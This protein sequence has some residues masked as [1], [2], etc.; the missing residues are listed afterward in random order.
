ML[1]NFVHYLSDLR[2][3]IP[4]RQCLGCYLTVDIMCLYLIF[5]DILKY[6]LTGCPMAMICSETMKYICVIAMFIIYNGSDRWSI[7][8][9]LSEILPVK[10]KGIGIYCYMLRISIYLYFFSSFILYEYRQHYLSTAITCTIIVNVLLLLFLFAQY[11][12]LKEGDE[13]LER[14]AARRFEK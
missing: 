3:R 4:L 11:R 14:V 12:I 1:L 6:F 5:A 8:E 13:Y 2:N 9:E 7:I 10:K